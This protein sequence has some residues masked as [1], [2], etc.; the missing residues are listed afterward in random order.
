MKIN[1][2][3]STFLTRCLMVALGCGLVVACASA[4][5]RN[6]TAERVRIAAA[7]MEDAIVVDCQLPGK[8]RKLGGTRTYLTPGRLIRASAIVCRTRGG[9]YTLG[10]LA[11]GTLSLQRWM[12]PA[13]KGDAEAQY[14]VARIHANGM[15]NVTIDYSKAAQWYQKAADQGFNEARQELGYLY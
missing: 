7:N 5:V 14:Y 9:E 13:G 12:I 6:E 4:E 15:D 3:E 2:A 1:T 8:L 10:D 11:S